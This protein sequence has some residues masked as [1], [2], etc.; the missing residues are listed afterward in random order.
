[1]LKRESCRSIRFLET[2]ISPFNQPSRA[3]FAGLAKRLRANLSEHHGFD[4]VLFPDCHKP[5]P[6]IRIGPFRVF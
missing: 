4:A 2:T 5:E 6:F 3:L 1:V